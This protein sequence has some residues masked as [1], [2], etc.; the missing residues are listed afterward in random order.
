MSQTTGLE[1]TDAHVLEPRTGLWRDRSLPAAVRARA[2][3]EQLT[4]SEKVAQLGSFWDRPDGSGSGEDGDVAPLQHAFDEA[5]RPFDEAIADGLG[6][7]TRPYGTAP[8]ST[9][10]GATA[11]RRA[12]ERIVSASRFGIPA[13]A[14]EECLTGFTAYG[15][16][17]YPSPLT[18]GATFDPELIA[19]VGA[20]IGADMRAVGAHQGLAPLLDVTRDYRWGRVEETIGEDPYLVGTIG[21]AYVRGLQSEGI[22]ATL[23]HFAGYSSS[24][25]GR[26]HAPVSVG[27]REFAD[28]ILTPFEM[29]I[30]EGGARSVMNSYSDIDGQPA[31]S[32]EDLLTGVLRDRWGFTGTVVSDYWAI[33]FL[34]LMHRTSPDRARS[35]AQA[36]AA[37]IDV[38]LPDADAYRRLPG[39]VDRGDLDVTVIDRAV[40]RVLTQKAELGLLDAPEIDGLPAAANPREPG[41][42]LDS[43]HNRE[44][45]R[46][47]AEAGIVLLQNDGILPLRAPSTVAV[48]GPCA[49][50]PRTFLGCYSFPNHVLAHQGDDLGV[51]VPSLLVG[52]RRALPDADV[53]HAPGVPILDDDLAGLPEAVAKAAAADIAIVAVGDLAALFGRGTSGEGCDAEDLRLPGRQ[54]DLVEAILATGTPVIL[55]VTSGRPYA[56]GA[57]AERCAAIVQAFMP[58]EEGG[59]ALASVLSGRVNPSGKLP[60]EIPARPGGQPHTYLAPPLGHSSDGISNLDTTPLFPFGFGLSY[61]EFEIEAPRVSTE[62]TTTDG[63]LEVTVRVR[64][65]GDRDGVEV[66]Q[67]Y[68]SDPVA[69]VTRP[70]MQLLGFARVAVPAG[71]SVDVRFQVHSDRFAFT[72]LR[73]ERVVEPGRIVLAAGGSSR[74]TQNIEVELT[75]GERAVPLPRLTTPWEVE[76]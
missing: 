53:T 11:L 6:Q 9:E 4:L 17:V 49:D 3:L 54:G 19:E 13:I 29:A 67:L 42:D 75:G 74:D 15:A 76:R 45:A 2:L 16:T 44:L 26:N 5:R 51:D 64:N 52:V 28:I 31:A 35:G 25:S 30:R 72:G 62:M 7:L 50:E 40:L 58:G 73:L 8:V 12:Q 65:T 66:V 57:Y 61:T 47:V 39:L 68:V 20:A 69:Q 41:R 23:K 18:W 10:E 37:G 27:P 59:A 24:R 38:E 33:P 63:A 14:H 1:P 55:V 46:R 21:S 48:V 36:I 34:D 70:V 60:V 56:L 32:S 22:V 43:A 71:A